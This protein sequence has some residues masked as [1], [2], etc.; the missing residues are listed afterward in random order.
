MSSWRDATDPDCPECGEPISATSEYCMHCGAE[1]GAPDDSADVSN[2]DDVSMRGEAAGSSA[3]GL[4]E[5]LGD[6]L[7]GPKRDSRGEPKEP[8][9]VK[10]DVETGDGSNGGVEAGGD[11]TVEAAAD[12][13]TTEKASTPRAPLSIR[14]FTAFVVSIPVT[15]VA[16]FVLMVLAES[17]LGGLSGFLFLTIWGVTLV[18][19]VRKPVPSDIIGDAFYVLAGLLLAGPALGYLLMVVRAS[20]TGVALDDSLG[21]LVAELLI[22]EFFVM[23]PAGVLAAIGYAGNWWAR[24]QLA[25]G[26]G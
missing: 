23:W 6:L 2:T 26:G 24:K 13:R 3:G 14:G 4:V 17:V 18:Y 11:A 22:I 12:T 16:F 9:H 5:K 15:L 10:S 25:E 20:V 19:L 1:F 8:D 7:G 21:A